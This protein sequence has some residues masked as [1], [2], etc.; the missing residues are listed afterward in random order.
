MSKSPSDAET[1]IKPKRLL[2]AKNLLVDITYHFLKRVQ[3]KR[4]VSE[5]A[6]LSRTAVYSI[7]PYLMNIIAK[8]P[9]I[10]GHQRKDLLIDATL[11][12]IEKYDEIM[13]KEQKV[14]N[15]DVMQWVMTDEFQRLIDKIY[16]KHKNGVA[17]RLNVKV[18]KKDIK[19][20]N[21]I[22]AEDLVETTIDLTQN[23]ILEHDVSVGCGGSME[24]S[25]YVNLKIKRYL[26]YMRKV[27]KENEKAFATK[28]DGVVVRS[29]TMYRDIP[30]DESYEKEK[31]EDEIRSLMKHLEGLSFQ[32]FSGILSK[33]QLKNKV[34]T[35]LKNHKYSGRVQSLILTPEFD[36]WAEGVIHKNKEAEMKKKNGPKKRLIGKKAIKD[37]IHVTSQLY[38]PSKPKPVPKARRAKKNQSPPPIPQK[39]VVT[40]G[41]G[42]TPNGK[43]IPSARRAKKT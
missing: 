26:K 20:A 32:E 42:S 13:N 29:M 8:I 33:D 7:L 28:N 43:V 14:D 11:G 12:G 38:N 25:K 31:M 17:F 5:H 10:R 22:Q 24:L 19:N 16:N 27:L 35:L 40:R 41:V 15:N 18:K 34:E 2:E 36:K 1:L 23:R 3:S 39:P 37:K 6:R 4:A 30:W 21:I 9:N